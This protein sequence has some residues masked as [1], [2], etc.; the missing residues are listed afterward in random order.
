MNALLT[1]QPPCL[2]E[3][4]DRIKSKFHPV[5]IILFGSWARGDAR[6]DS[7]V[8]LLVVLPKVDHKRKAAIQIGNSL[9][10]LPIS[11]DIIVTTP[12]EIASRGNIVGNILRPALEEGKIIYESR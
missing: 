5:Q 6:E 7:D 9:S 11:K 12:E 2:P 4:V 8:D 3:V 10:N 1:N